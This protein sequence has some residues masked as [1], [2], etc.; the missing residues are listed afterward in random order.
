M[1]DTPHMSKEALEKHE[2]AKAQLEYEKSV[3]LS[4]YAAGIVDA[5]E[6]RHDDFERGRLYGHALARLQEEE[7]LMIVP[8]HYERHELW[9]TARPP[10]FRDLPYVR[11]PGSFG[12]DDRA[13]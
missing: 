12:E 1:S 2:E 6:L 9:K 5:V 10:R 7:R 4:G 3:Y 8:E 11:A 13:R